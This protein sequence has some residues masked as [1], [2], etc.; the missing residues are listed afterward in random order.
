MEDLRS[1]LGRD[2][3]PNLE[4]VT[5]LAEDDDE[6]CCPSLTM[7]ERIVGTI[8]CFCLGTLVNVLAMMKIPRLLLGDPKPFAAAYTLGNL[9]S[10]CS[11]TFLVGPVRPLFYN[12]SISL[13]T[14]AD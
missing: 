12:K 10:L 5:N 1:L 14:N 11:T 13:R 4:D 3:A 8:V 2:R 6:Q 7:F 9:L